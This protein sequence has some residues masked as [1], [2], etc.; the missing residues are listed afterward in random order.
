MMMAYLAI[1]LFHLLFLWCHNRCLHRRRL[2][3]NHNITSSIHISI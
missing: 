2:S 3:A 1:E